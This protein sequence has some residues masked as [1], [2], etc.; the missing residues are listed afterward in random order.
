VYKRWSSQIKAENLQ[1]F[2]EL[3]TEQILMQIKPTE[4]KIKKKQRKVSTEVADLKSKLVQTSKSIVLSNREIRLLRYMDL[5]DEEKERLKGYYKVAK[6]LEK[7]ESIGNPKGE[8][9]DSEDE[10]EVNEVDNYP[11]LD[12]VP[13]DNSMSGT[14]SPRFCSEPPSLTESMQMMDEILS[15]QSM[16]RV[17]K[18]DKLEAILSAVTM[19]PS[20]QIITSNNIQD[21]LGSAIATTDN[22]QIVRDKTKTFKTNNSCACQT[23]TTTPDR[24]DTPPMRL[25]NSNGKQTLPVKTMQDASS[26]TLS[27][28]DIVITKIYFQD[29]SE[30]G[31]DKVLISSRRGG[32]SIAQ[33]QN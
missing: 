7:M 32:V 16:D 30:K 26:Q 21:Q 13:S 18:I 6:K 22:L 27:T 23:P 12:S 8:A 5:T 20:D 10:Q 24:S 33:P 28:G 1:L 15:D 29:E 2:S 25:M 17:A 4:V 19:L 11:S 9:S 31:K 3:C 14:F